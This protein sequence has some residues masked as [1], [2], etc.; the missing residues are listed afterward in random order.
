MSKFK[1]ILSG[2][3]GTAY[4]MTDDE[5]AELLN[6]S[7]EEVNVDETLGTLK[8]KDR[9]RVS[10]LQ[11]NSFDEGYKKAEKREKNEFEKKLKTKFDIDSDKLGDEL[12]E[13]I[14]EATTS[15]QKT[16]KS[17]MTDDDVKKHPAFVQ[18]ENTFK[19]QLKEQKEDFENQIHTK[20]NEYKKKETFGN[21]SKQA[22]KIFESLNPILS[23]NP[24]KAANQKNDFVAKLNGYE[25]EVVEGKVIISKD[26]AVLEDGHG[27]KID[28]EK[29]VKST[30]EQFY[31]F[32]VA[33]SRT[34]PGS[35]TTSTEPPRFSSTIKTKAD[36]ERAM[37]SAKSLVEKKSIQEAFDKIS[38]DSET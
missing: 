33:E 13:E 4:K 27:N 17:S 26:G 12:I 28:F 25:Y 22:L 1:A 7:D 6:K 23:S 24:E 38:V 36:Y 8:Q 2:L 5:V 35:T 37:N 19:K 14:F 32:K 30:A 11:K 10:L 18:M 16:S 34:A 3:L 15:K 9:D 29:F 21:V 31:D 20:E